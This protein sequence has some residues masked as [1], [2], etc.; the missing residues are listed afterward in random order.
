MKYVNNAYES[1]YE[2]L[3]TTMNHQNPTS[4]QYSTTIHIQLLSVTI[5]HHRFCSTLLYPRTKRLTQPPL[6]RLPVHPAPRSRCRCR[7]SCKGRS[8][9]PVAQGCGSDAA[10]AVELEQ[11]GTRRGPNPAV[12]NIEI[13]VM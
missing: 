2:S 8:A 9:P 7:S 10:A 13:Y 3:S 6:G 5:N 4:N 1:L 11:G 12:V